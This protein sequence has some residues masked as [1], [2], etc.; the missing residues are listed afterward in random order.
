MSEP[1]NAIPTTPAVDAGTPAPVAPKV[2]VKPAVK[3]D[4]HGVAAEPAKKIWKLKVNGKEVDYDASDEAKLRNDVQRVIGIEEKAN[5]ASQKAE[6]AEKLLTMMQTDYKGFLK[7]C[8]ASGINAEKLAAD[9]LYEKIRQGN[10]T[11]EQRE[12]EEYKERE[13]EAATRKKADE[14]AA[15]VA[16]STRKTQEWAA[17]FEADCSAAL[18]ANKIP[19]TRLALALVAQ[20]IDAGLTKKQ[21]LSVEQV[22]PYVQ[23]DLKEIHM[24]TMGK[25]DGDDLL[26]YVG[27]AL[28]NKIAKAR[29][30]RYKRTSAVSAPEAKPAATTKKADDISHLKGSAYWAARRRI[31]AQEEAARLAAERQQ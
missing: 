2:D 10:M 30:E 27:E 17:K 20:Y 21:E 9:I 28:S 16:E 14:E 18:A 11:P 24:S 4:E 15:K 6:Q 26:E 3:V 23:R 12:L 29:V 19:K 13:A 31:A 1:V 5:T 22:L 25:L 7:Q 8:K